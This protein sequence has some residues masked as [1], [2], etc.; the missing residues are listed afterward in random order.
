MWAHYSN[1]HTGVCLEFSTKNILFG[2]A[3]EVSYRKDYPKYDLT[4]TDELKNIEPFLTKS[5]AWKYEGEYRLVA[6]EDRNGV[7]K[8]MLYTQDNFLKI[9][10]ESLKSIII[11]CMAPQSTIDEVKKLADLSPSSIRVMQ[12]VKSHNKYALSP[13]EI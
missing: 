12:T 3:P 6:K 1:K 4:S 11:G 8:Y 13:M 2:G 5:D 9:P 7:H 10:D